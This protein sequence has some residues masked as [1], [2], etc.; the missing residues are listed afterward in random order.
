[1]SSLSRYI[2]YVV[3]FAQTDRYRF[4]KSVFIDNP[5]SY[6]FF[7]S[8]F[9]DNPCSYRFFKSVFIYNPCSYRFFRS[10]FIYNPCRLVLE[11]TGESSINNYN[12]RA[13]RQE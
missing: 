4:F 2:S 1:M 9:I 8:V 5:C 7:K 6:R 12:A 10:V 11:N 13:R 3:E